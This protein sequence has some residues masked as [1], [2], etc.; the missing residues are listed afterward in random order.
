MCAQVDIT[1][2]HGV[3]DQLLQS[4]PELS[5]VKDITDHSDTSNAYY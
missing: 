1:L 2:K 5:G 4:V 3:E